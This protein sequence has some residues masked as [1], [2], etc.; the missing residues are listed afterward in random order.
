MLSGGIPREKM[1]KDHLVRIALLSLFA[2]H[3][4]N[5]MVIIFRDTTPFIADASNYYLFSFQYWKKWTEFVKCWNFDLLK[6]LLGGG[7]GGQLL[8]LLAIPFFSVFG[9]S[10][11]I[12]ILANQSFFLILIFSIFEL[13]KILFNRR[14]GLL[15]AYMISFYPGVVGFSRV[16][17]AE[18]PILAIST[19]CVYLL[20]KSE[21]FKNLKYSLC[22][23]FAFALGE[24]IR[25]RFAVYIVIPVLFYAIKN[26]AVLF[27]HTEVSAQ[28]AVKKIGLNIL[29]SAA[30]SCLLLFPWYSIG[31]VS[32]YLSFQKL[33]VSLPALSH[34]GSNLPYYLQMLWEVQLGWFFAF[35][36]FLGMLISFFEKNKRPKIYFLFMWFGLTMVLLSTLGLKDFPRITI[37]LLVPVALISSAGM[38]RLSRLKIGKY[39]W[40]SFLLFGVFQYFFISYGNQ[41]LVGRD[42]RRRFWGIALSHGLLQAGNGDWALDELMSTFEVRGNSEKEWGWRFIQNINWLARFPKGTDDFIKVLDIDCRGTPINN[43]IEERILTNELA[44]VVMYLYAAP[45]NYKRLFSDRNLQCMVLGADYVIKHEEAP[46]EGGF[47]DKIRGIFDANISRFEKLKTVETPWGKISIYGRKKTGAAGVNVQTI[48][49][50]DAGI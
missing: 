2:F 8:S 31:N 20:I 15:A 10:H 9:V 1:K 46:E 37:P 24:L 45:F 23:G 14:T 13:G 25:P 30:I 44:I 40:V 27:R 42:E 22:F 6:T 34:I 36:F 12:A 7:L 18:F 21:G 16:Y 48:G 35:L 19:V 41:G 17:M 11:D 33:W 26:M 38:E 32:G 47:I 29:F 3:L 50:K 4:I 39:L 5:N 43:D 49:E 28:T